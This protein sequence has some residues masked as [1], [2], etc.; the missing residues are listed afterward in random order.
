MGTAA[1][2]HLL[3]NRRSCNICIFA[4][5]IKVVSITAQNWP[6][7]FD[8]LLRNRSILAAHYLPGEFVPKR[9]AITAA[10]IAD[11]LPVHFAAGVKLRLFWYTVF[12]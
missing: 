8:R 9:L 2:A 4:T 6:I 5:E 3:C 1:S 7:K 11:V 12:L 10:H